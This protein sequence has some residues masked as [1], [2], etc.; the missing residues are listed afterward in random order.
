MGR[1][2]LT[3][4][5]GLSKICPPTFPLLRTPGLPT[6]CSVFCNPHAQVSNGS[7]ANRQGR[8]QVGCEKD[9]K[10]CAPL[11]GDRGEG[12]EQLHCP[13]AHHTLAS[14][15][16]AGRLQW[17]QAARTPRAFLPPSGTQACVKVNA[18][19]LLRAC[20]LK[21]EPDSLPSCLPEC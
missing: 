16:R 7:F 17:W 9:G 10:D 11:K 3:E 1:R 21:R 15:R 20:F 8:C 18:N 12:A 2:K 13:A 5:C 6:E 4:H 14:T 19:Q